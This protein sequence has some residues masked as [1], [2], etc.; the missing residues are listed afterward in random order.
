[1][2]VDL[3]TRT[4]LHVGWPNDSFPAAPARLARQKAAN[5]A[6]ATGLHSSSST[7]VCIHSR[8]NLFPPAPPPQAPARR[9][10]LVRAAGA[11]R[12][13]QWRLQRRSP[14]ELAGL[15]AFLPLG[16]GSWQRLPSAQWSG[17][18]RCLGGI[19]TWKLTPGVERLRP[20][21]WGCPRNRRER[22]WLNIMVL[23]WL[24]MRIGDVDVKVTIRIFH[25]T[26]SDCVLWIDRINS[27]AFQ[28]TRYSTK[29]H[30]E[31]SVRMKMP[32]RTVHLSLRIPPIG[33]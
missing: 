32:N 7:I 13:E 33:L 27:I 19:S 15:G 16:L 10:Q 5:F 2:Y 26:P 20:P 17:Q 14:G 6:A 30:W 31:P 18:R 28:T 11:Q 21:S 29:V 12:Q 9:C 4:Y 8:F 3:Y 22:W 23:P 25:G 24:R 1:M